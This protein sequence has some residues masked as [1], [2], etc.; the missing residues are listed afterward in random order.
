[1][2]SFTDNICQTL[3]KR[4]RGD[5]SH[6]T[7]NLEEEFYRAGLVTEKYSEHWVSASVILSVLPSWSQNGCHNSK[8]HILTQLE[9]EI[10][11]SLGWRNPPITCFPL[12]REE[13]VSES[14]RSCPEQER[15]EG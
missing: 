5:F 10:T 1:M 14:P 4:T 9:E 7:R 15:K 6:V 2:W 8:H 13:T 11:E 3:A 12:F